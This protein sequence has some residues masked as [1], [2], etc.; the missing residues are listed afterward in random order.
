ML[1]TLVYP[2]AYHLTHKEACQN[3]VPVGAQWAEAP[4]NWFHV[5]PAL[6]IGITTIISVNKIS[7][8]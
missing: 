6:D 8:T 3:P 4:N 7:Q 1:N 5:W 2:R